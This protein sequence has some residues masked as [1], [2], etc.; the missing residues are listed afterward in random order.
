MDKRTSEEPKH[1]TEFRGNQQY[2]S[3]DKIDQTVDLSELSTGSDMMQQMQIMMMQQQKMM[4]T[5][6]KQMEMQQLQIQQLQRKPAAVDEPA[7]EPAVKTAKVVAEEQAEPETETETADRRLPTLAL[8]DYTGAKYD[9][10]PAKYITW[11]QTIIDALDKNKVGRCIEDPD[12][13]GR[14]LN[15]TPV[16]PG[17]FLSSLIRERT[18]L[19]TVVGAYITQSLTGSILTEIQQLKK[20]RRKVPVGGRS[21]L[22]AYEIFTT[23]KKESNPVLAHQSRS[24]ADR[25]FRN[26]PLQ[27]HAGRL[28]VD[29]YIK[30]RKSE[31]EYLNETGG[32]EDRISEHS[33]VMQIINGI[34]VHHEQAYRA[35]LSDSKDA[36][37][38]YSL[39][40]LKGA[41]DAQFPKSYN[42]SK[43]SVH[44]TCGKE[45]CTHC[46]KNNHRSNN[47]FYRPDVV[48]DKCGVKGHHAHRCKA[49]PDEAK[50]L[51]AKKEKQAQMTKER[52]ERQKAY[53]A[54][55][56]SME[57]Q[58]VQQA[59]QQQPS[60]VKPTH[61]DTAFHVAP[62]VP[63]APPVVAEMK[64]VHLPSGV[65]VQYRDSC[66]LI[67]NTGV[68][69]EKF[70][71]PSD[72]MLISAQGN[73]L[74]APSYEGNSKLIAST[75]ARI[76][77]TD[78]MAEYNNAIYDSNVD[79]SLA[80]T[81][82]DA[83]P[84]MRDALTGL[85]SLPNVLAD[86]TY[87]M[88]DSPPVDAAKWTMNP[89]WIDSLASCCCVK[90]PLFIH[91]A[92]P[93]TAEDRTDGF[94][95]SAVP[96]K[97]GAITLRILENT[98]TLEGSKCFNQ[99]TNVDILSEGQ[100]KELNYFVDRETNTLKCPSGERIPLTPDG[101][102]DR[103]LRFDV[104]VYIGDDPEGDPDIAMIATSKLT[105]ADMH[106][107][108]SHPS[109]PYLDKTQSLVDGFPAKALTR[110]GKVPCE[111]CPEAKGHREH[112]YRDPDRSP[113]LW[114]PG[115]A[116]A[117]DTTRVMPPSIQD[118][119][120]MN[121]VVKRHSGFLVPQH[122][123]D[124]KSE[125]LA[126]AFLSFIMR[127]GIPDHVFVDGGP[128]YWGSFNTLC[129]SLLVHISRSAP[130]TH[131]QNPAEVWMRIIGQATR[132]DM[133][134]SGAPIEFYSECF[135][136]C[137][138]SKNVTYS[139]STP[140]GLTPYEEEFGRRPDISMRRPFYCPCR[141]L[142][143]D[144][145]GTYAP[146]T[147]KGRFMRLALGYKAWKIY[148]PE[149]QCFVISRHVTFDELPLTVPEPDPQVV[150]LF[151]DDLVETPITADT[152]LTDGEA[153]L[154]SQ[155]GAEIAQPG[156]PALEDADLSA[157]PPDVG[158]QGRY[159]EFQEFSRRRHDEYK[160]ADL[161]M[162]YQSMNKVIG[163]E[164]QDFKRGIAPPKLMPTLPAGGAQIVVDDHDDD[165]PLTHTSTLDAGGVKVINTE[166]APKVADSPPPE[167]PLHSTPATPPSNASPAPDPDSVQ[168]RQSHLQA[169][170]LDL[171]RLRSAAARD[172]MNFISTAADVLNTLGE[173][174]DCITQGHFSEAAWDML[175]LLVEDPKTMKEGLSGKDAEQWRQAI[176]S[177][178]QSL[179]DLEVY[180]AIS[181]RE[182]PKGKR[183]LLSKI[184]LKYKVW[185]KRYKARLVVL[186]F[187]QPDEDV[188]DT[189]APVAKFTTFR[190]LMAIACQFD[191][192]ISSSDV[193]TAFLNA[194]LDD[195][196]YILPPKGL[197]IDPDVVWRLKKCL[198]GLKGSPHFWNLT[199]H[200]WLISIGFE[201][202]PVDPC[203]YTKSGLFVLIWVDDALKVGT[204][205]MIAWFEDEFDKRFVGTH[206]AEVEMFVGIEI[207]RDRASRTLELRQTEYIDKFLK[208]FG[209]FDS[210]GEATPMASGTVISKED[211]CNGDHELTKQYKDKHFDVRAAA[212]SMLYATICTRP[213]AAF[214]VKETCKIMADPGPKHV[215]IVKR[216][217][218]Y[219][220]RTR[221]KGLKYTAVAGEVLGTFAADLIAAAWADASFADDVD[222]RRST[223]GFVAKLL[224]G[225]IAWFSQT[226]KCITL[227]TT[228]AE[229]YALSDAIKEVIYIRST[230]AHLGFPQ[231][232]PTVIWEDNAA[233]VATA[234][235]PGKNH[236][237]LKHVTTRVKYVQEHV[238][239]IQTVEVEKE[240]DETMSADIL[241]KA[242][243]IPQH[244]PKADDILGYKQ[245]KD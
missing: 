97:A 220:R 185:D 24:Q 46:G 180:D 245:L 82:M 228:E 135:A 79:L 103:F 45:K 129:L 88:A 230:L 8:G 217:L 132:C 149:Q 34:Q 177:E 147:V 176:Q 110:G 207:I 83:V 186:G 138:D 99:M 112:I 32:G 169:P 123:V 142:I 89:F 137:T 229:L 22:T 235:N 216:I 200:D 96:D 84:D 56:K 145:V 85:E 218:K 33:L 43:E 19:Q 49:N 21:T 120:V 212:A 75:M 244:G 239:E 58:L 222:S 124:K 241:T 115:E 210:N 1:H 100:L 225:A 174:G 158:K 31:W 213:D 11:E 105:R 214:A 164:W 211:C 52:K 70:C 39:T 64:T 178:L 35:L 12:Y 48:C 80:Y 94:A 67:M 199:F 9:G 227:S 40:L 206:T 223:Q 107:R 190:I 3:P 167:T 125:T 201:Q 141:V 195:H 175:C 77:Y 23:V 130:E 243:G 114:A 51:K 154:M 55:G 36:Y 16:K 168:R 163:S 166:I 171:P 240:A 242:L 108:L 118:G 204:T 221:T 57:Q 134:D 117:M 226:Q 165:M 38:K 109:D 15:Q 153:D 78:Y 102:K 68:L 215:S 189:F 101:P 26:T 197:G 61:A 179:I 209:F 116:V 234:N 162:D 233:V 196:I 181:R 27:K 155:T 13:Q 29:E 7:T 42:Y 159:K 161:Y 150:T 127:H 136:N 182:V 66:N 2:P 62:P 93:I 76:D 231:T 198:Y 59:A 30:E 14:Y 194:I 44:L 72:V 17:A 25:Q 144:P 37:G 50:Q 74:Y 160:Q 140:N 205:D 41:I 184:V 60:K 81:N 172:K 173:H 143:H 95:G 87:V 18:D 63:N 193:K 192:E 6:T 170:P 183:L 128:E 65:T 91:S 113:R 232:Q 28:A 237:K 121:L 111:R 4:E 73:P 148:L 5:L 86:E 98:E 119:T 156:P 203:L 54:M 151:E 219:F 152:E 90:N 202:S 224:G 188:G 92:R 10:S 157:R 208:R 238:L 71:P 126:K 122:L 69:T 191:F 53:I 133:L 131:E 236:G 187:M 146:R 47:C 20:A 104:W 106:R 139:K